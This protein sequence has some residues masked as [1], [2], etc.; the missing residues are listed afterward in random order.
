M[1]HAERAR[2]ER[3]FNDVRRLA[4]SFMFEIHDAIENLPGS[5]PARRLLVERALEYLD[6]LTQEAGDDPSLQRELAMAYQ[7]VGD[8]QG[9]PYTA[10]LGDTAGALQ[11]FR[12]A[13]AI[14]EALSTQNPADRQLRREWAVNY[15]LIAD[16]L[17]KAGDTTGALENIRQAQTHFEALSAQDPANAENHRDLSVSYIKIG[18][19]VAQ[20]GDSSQALKNYR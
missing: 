6:R 19:V 18:G 11:S 12:K 14:R 3:R 8:V 16:T 15:G 10:N 2:A 7:K 20:S 4:N 9:Y 1:A 5:T 17:A 13:L